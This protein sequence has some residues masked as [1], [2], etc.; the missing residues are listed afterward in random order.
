[1][2]INENNPQK[3]NDQKPLQSGGGGAAEEK[4]KRQ[5]RW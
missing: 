1:M 3:E 4:E 2:T 5:I